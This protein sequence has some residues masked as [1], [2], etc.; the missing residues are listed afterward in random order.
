MRSIQIIAILCGFSLAVLLTHKLAAQE[1]LLIVPG[2]NTQS[3]VSLDPRGLTVTDQNGRVTDYRRE[4]Q[5]DSPD[6]LWLGFFSQLNNQVLRWPASHRGNL[7]IGQPSPAGWIYRASKM[8]VQPL[9]INP[10][11]GLSAG[12]GLGA[13]IMPGGG[14]APG[15]FAAVPLN[16]IQQIGFY[17]LSTADAAARGLVLDV[18]GSAIVSM[19]PDQN[20]DTQA[21]RVIPVVND[22]VRIQGL[23]GGAAQS[24]LTLGPTGPLAMAPLDQSPGQLWRLVPVFGAQNQVWFESV[25]FPGRALAGSADGLVAIERL[26]NS[27]AQAWLMQTYAPPQPI[28]PALTIVSRS[29]V[30]SPQLE[31]AA[32][33][34]LNSSRRDILVSLA[35]RRAGHPIKEYQI[36]AGKSETVTLDR[37]SGGRF[38]EAYEVRT[39]L[40]TVERQ[41]FETRVPPAIYYDISVYEISLKSIAIDRT[42]KSPNAIED[43]NYQPK[44]VGWFP[45]PPGAAL[46]S[47]P[48]DVVR[49]AREA[50]N[51]GGVRPLSK[52]GTDPAADPPDVLEKILEKHRRD[53]ER[54]R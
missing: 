19:Q 8:T 6:A 25:A 41:E 23:R 27:P 28:L 7:Q 33:Q 31:P 46:T 43:V 12:I 35:D 34:L 1:F 42:G 20:S 13:E 14:I 26:S 21:W 53:Q 37:D 9:A 50:G 49:I 2:T 29:L 18:F 24:L 52:P 51:P 39:P 22:V 17:Q 48:L 45:L 40:G 4:P 10:G 16:S 36:S 47:G 3:T 44:S 54:I 11:I 15:A 38:V 5:F 30:P 32:V